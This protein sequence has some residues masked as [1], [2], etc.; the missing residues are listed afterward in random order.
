MTVASKSVPFA[1]VFGYPI[2]HSLS[3]VLHGTWLERYRIEGRYTA[4][5]VASDE[6][7][8]T[9]ENLARTPGFRGGNVTVPHKEAAFA[10]ADE[11]DEAALAIGAVNTLVMLEDGRISGRNTDAYGFAE[12]LKAAE[13]WDLRPQGHAVVLGAGGAARAVIHA[14]ITL[15]FDDIRIVNRTMERAERISL[16]VG[17]G[18]THVVPV[19]Q[20]N[21]DA[22]DG[23]ALLV[24]TTT[25]GMVGQPPL[26]VDLKALQTNAIVNDIVYNPLE[27]YLLKM[28][29]ARGNPTVDGLGMLLH[30]AVPGFVAWFNPPETPAVDADLRTRVLAH[31]G[32]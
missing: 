31:L 28:A 8:A 10:L 24:N 17:Q 20:Q 6:F 12:N 30:Q 7:A 9:L 18:R 26:E 3:P 4:Y 22:L 13:C 2:R 5:E 14:L 29:K 23:A 16:E 1:H 32:L 21:Q 11:K 27:T 25:L 19:S 15:G